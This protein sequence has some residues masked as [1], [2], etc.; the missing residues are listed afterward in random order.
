MIIEKLA[1]NSASRLSSVFPRSSGPKKKV[2]VLIY[3]VLP[4]FRKSIAFWK[5]SRLHQFVLMIRA[6]YRWRWVQNI[7]G[8][9]LTGKTEVLGEKPVPAPLCSTQFSHGLI[10]DRARASA[11]KGGR[12]T[13]WATAQPNS[14][15]IKLQRLNSYLTENTVCLH[16][17]GQSLNMIRK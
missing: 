11:V 3:P 8:M 5:V 17:K 4:D 9:T 7:G 16:K 2:K 12:I 10:W 15:K 1:N 13:A 6:T 14:T